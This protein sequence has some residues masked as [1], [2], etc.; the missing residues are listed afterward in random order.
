M[1]FRIVYNPEVINDI[2]E[3]VNW[4]NEQEKIVMIEAV[5]NTKR[6]PEIWKEKTKK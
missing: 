1:S 4:Y 5:I 2:Q 6:N 3:A